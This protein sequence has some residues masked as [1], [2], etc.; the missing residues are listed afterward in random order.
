MKL[1]EVTF[2]NVGGLKTACID[3]RQLVELMLNTA[4]EYKANLTEKNIDSF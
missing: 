4:K 1:E 3:R 2:T